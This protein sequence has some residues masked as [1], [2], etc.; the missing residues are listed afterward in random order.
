MTGSNPTWGKD[1]QVQLW[2]ADFGASKSQLQWAYRKARGGMGKQREIWSFIRS[3]WSERG[4]WAASYFSII[5]SAFVGCCKKKKKTKIIWWHLVKNSLTKECSLLAEMQHFCPCVFVLCASLSILFLQVWKVKT[6]LLSEFWS[7]S[8][9]LWGIP[10][11]LVCEW[12]KNISSIAQDRE[13]WRTVQA[14][15]KERLLLISLPG[16]IYLLKELF[17]F[18]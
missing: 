4:W 6:L 1:S 7:L 14:A 16:D 9:K 12:F 11:V 10:S 13:H 2:N 18:R 15:G 8:E 3:Y 5:T 17:C